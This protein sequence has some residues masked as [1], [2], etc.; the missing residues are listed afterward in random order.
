MTGTCIQV[1]PES[2]QSIGA[3]GAIATIMYIIGAIVPRLPIRCVCV[4]GS[5]LCCVCVL[6]W[7]FWVCLFVCLCQCPFAYARGSVVAAMGVEE[8]LSAWVSG[9]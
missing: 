2:A 7:L 3:F 1:N 4:C 9:C 5:V 6:V 8:L